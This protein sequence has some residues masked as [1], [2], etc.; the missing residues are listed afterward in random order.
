MMLASTRTG[1]F[2]TTSGRNHLSAG[3][4]YCND[5]SN[6]RYGNA[7]SSKAIELDVL[8]YAKGSWQTASYDDGPSRYDSD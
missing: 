5:T 7:V 6:C 3:K 8:D 4:Q 2:Q 1:T